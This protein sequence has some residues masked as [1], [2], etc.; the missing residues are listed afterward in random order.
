MKNSRSILL[1]H[2]SHRTFATT[3]TFFIGLF[4]LNLRFWHE[5]TV[6]TYSC[7]NFQNSS[8]PGF[9]TGEASPWFALRC[10][11]PPRAGARRP[12][13]PR[14]LLVYP[15][16]SHNCLVARHSPSLCLG[17]KKSESLSRFAPCEIR[18]RLCGYLLN[19]LFHVNIGPEKDIF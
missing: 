17:I 18:W 10:S 19:F 14:H 13:T 1:I 15:R 3:I 6:R 8:A 11:P 9:T 7:P 4:V 12:A 2:K 16:K 5:N